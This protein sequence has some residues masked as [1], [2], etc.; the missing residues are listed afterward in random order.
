MGNFHAHKRSGLARLIAANLAIFVLLLIVVEGLASYVVV[1]RFIMLTNNIVERR[2]TKYDPDLG[3]VNEP[4]I[5]ISDMYGPGIYLRT[6]SQG[7]RN[8]H[9]ISPAVPAGKAR[10]ICSGDSFTLG[11]GVDNDHA[12]CNRLSLLDP[13]I[14]TVNMGQGGYGVD[15]AY[16][17]YKRDSAK[18][19]HQVHLFAFITSDFHRMQSDSF[20]GYAKPLLDTV[21]GALVVKNVPIPKR[22]YSFPSIMQYYYKDSLGFLRT[23]DVLTRAMRKIGLAGTD[24]RN[25][26]QRKRVEKDE[27][28][29]KILHEIFEDLK[30]INEQRSSKLVLIYL[31]DM[32]TLAGETPGEW[33]EFLEGESR[34]LGVPLINLVSEFGALPYQEVVPL[35]ISQK[36]MARG[37]LSVAGN[38]LVSKLIHDKLM[39]APTISAALQARLR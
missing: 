14:E 33:T 27:H 16:L 11:Y 34:S 26:T 21:N 12:W 28:T 3:W 32:D 2:H 37:H 24:S 9:D 13:R 7:F 35:F 4:S 18:I 15:Q 10:I 31:P 30:N 22:D 5:N 29:R 19:E 8:N 23:V 36:Q 38:N 25:T 20:R 17:W 1:A 6:N 39:N